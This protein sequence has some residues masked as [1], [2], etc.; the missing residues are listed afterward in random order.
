M[1]LINFKSLI[2]NLSFSQFGCQLVSLF[3][4]NRRW[5][6]T[7]KENCK[8]SFKNYSKSNNLRSSA[9]ETDYCSMKIAFAPHAISPLLQ[10]GPLHRRLTTHHPLQCFS[11]SGNLQQQQLRVFH[12]LHI[13]QFSLIPFEAQLFFFVNFPSQLKPPTPQSILIICKCKLQLIIKTKGF[14]YNQKLSHCVLG[15]QSGLGQAELCCAVRSF[16]FT[17]KG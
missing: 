7:V 15:Q 13:K 14:I 1:K 9:S 6:K 11:R 2:K 4:S 10:N 8:S 5:N 16:I 12:H 3:F 17:K